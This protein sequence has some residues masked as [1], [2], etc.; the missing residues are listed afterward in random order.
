MTP[1]RSA[2]FQYLSHISWDRFVEFVV[3]ILVHVQKHQLVDNTDGP[4]D[5]KQ[6]ILTIDPGG[7]RHLTQCKHTS[8]F[9][10]NANG[11]DLDTLFAAC[12]RKNCQRARYVTNADLT[13]QAKR[14]I[15][16]AEYARGWPGSLDSKKRIR[17]LRACRPESE[18]H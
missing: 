10:D 16:D 12:L 9:D 7:Q 6:D 13:V 18:R 3:D 15:T 1:E 2:I 14:Y 8:K 5:E 17:R 11:D 4:G